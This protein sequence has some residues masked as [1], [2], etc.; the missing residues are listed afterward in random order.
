M[1]HTI[2]LLATLL[3]ISSRAQFSDD[4]SAGLTGWTTAGDVAVSQEEAVLADTAANR[5]YLA[6]GT[7]LDGFVQLSFDIQPQLAEELPPGT[8]LDTFF[9]SIFFFLDPQTFNPTDT[10]T[11]L[12]AIGLLDADA[13]GLY[14]IQG[15]VSASAKG[16]DWLTFTGSFTNAA[17]YAAVAYELFDANTVDGD[18]VVLIDNVRMVPEPGFLGHLLTAFLCLR[19]L[20]SRVRARAC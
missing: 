16:P 13:L 6:R 15:A 12:E 2:F 17:P 14:N 20:K 4:F 11:F 5:S 7:T 10:N 3:T 1:R 9:A 19:L 8:F 18:S